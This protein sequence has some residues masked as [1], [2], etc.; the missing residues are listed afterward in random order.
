MQEILP[1]L[2]KDEQFALIDQLRRAAQSIPANI[3]EGFGRHHYQDAV[4][5][6]YIARGSLVEVFSHLT[7]AQK[8]G[9]LPED[10]YTTLVTQLQN[11]HIT[12]NGYITFL[13]RSKQGSNEPDH[14]VHEPAPEYL[15]EETDEPAF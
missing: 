1:K 9:Y 4:R 12:S 5:F 6:S 2:P 15:Y 3:A 13:K 8:M 11:L 10:Q 14:A 7:Y